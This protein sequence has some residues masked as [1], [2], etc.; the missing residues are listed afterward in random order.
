MKLPRNL[1]RQRYTNKRG[2]VVYYYFAQYHDSQGK[3]QKVPLGSSYKAAR[4]RLLDVLAEHQRRRRVPG[5]LI[6]FSEWAARYKN[7]IANKASARRDIGMILHLEAFLGDLPLSRITS[8]RI[9]EYRNAR[10]GSGVMR[11]GKRTERKVMASTVNRELSCLRTMLNLAAGDHLITRD[12]LP[13][14]KMDSEERFVRDRVLSDDE[15]ERYLANSPLWFHRIS[16]AAYETA[17]SRKD[18]ILMTWDRVDLKAGVIRGKRFKTGARQVVAITKALAPILDEMDRK[19][20]EDRSPDGLVFTNA[21][22]PITGDMLRTAFDKVVRKAKITGF[23]FHDFRHTAKTR[24]ARH[25]I[26]PEVAMLAAG[27]RSLRMH[28]RYVDLNEHD[29]VAAFK[30]L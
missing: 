13:R 21:G 25:G 24:W 1:S 2:K 12:E 6:T 27:Q 3:R 29:I 4:D 15:Y 16:V 17:L 11:W 8:T 7:L 28:Y 14:I 30:D 26:T 20:G 5:E 22:R 10:T 19:Q 23:T 18:L 9:I